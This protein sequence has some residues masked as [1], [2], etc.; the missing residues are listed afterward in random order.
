M[1]SSASLPPGR[2]RLLT[3]ALPAL[4]LLLLLL[5]LAA[6]VLFGSSEVGEDRVRYTIRVAL[7]FYCL[8]AALLLSLDRADWQTASPLVCLARLLW[9]LTLAAYIV[10]VLLAF[11]YYH[12]WSH[13]DAFARTE[14]V[15]GFG[16]GIY[17]SHLFGLLWAV[18]A[19]WWWFA[20]DSYARRSPGID[21]LLN[22]FMAFIIFN[23]SVVF[24]EGLVRWA[25]VVMFL[26]LAGLLLQRL[27][28]RRSGTP[29]SLQ[30]RSLGG[31]PRET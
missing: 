20:P 31:I 5:A 17:I 26:L 27:L 18:D 11:H 4:W 7:L 12:H 30:S 8:A 2:V 28:R 13:A 19:A 25:S 10:H 6:P 15:S 16:P 9:S 22:S 21:W 3:I 24:A 1:P 29:G 14:R 23:G